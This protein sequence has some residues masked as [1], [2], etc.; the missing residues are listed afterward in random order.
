MC[1]LA[2]ASLEERW[3]QHAT[4][5]AVSLVRSHRSEVR[6]AAGVLLTREATCTSTTSPIPFSEANPL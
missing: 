5:R 3:Y 2:G 4:A 1:S 6:I